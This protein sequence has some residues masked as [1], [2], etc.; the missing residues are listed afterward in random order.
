MILPQFTYGNRRSVFLCAVANQ[1]RGGTMR[2]SGN[3]GSVPAVH[4]VPMKLCIISSVILFLA[5]SLVS[6]CGK[7]EKEIARD[8]KSKGNL[9]GSVQAFQ[10]LKTNYVRPVVG[11]HGE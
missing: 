6:S 4:R 5:N 10:I 9:S 8:E 7:E 3:I 11:E 1:K 2:S